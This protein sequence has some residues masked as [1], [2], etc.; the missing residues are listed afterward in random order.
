MS[1][2]PLTE[3]EDF[4]NEI[5]DTI[6]TETDKSVPYVFEHDFESKIIPLLQRPWD[7]NNLDSYR[8]YVHELFN[9]LRVFSYEP[10]PKV[11]F[12]VPALYPRPYTT[13]VDDP[14]AAT[15]GN[16]VEHLRLSAGRTPFAG[17]ELLLDFMTKI[18]IRE[19]VEVSTLIPLAKILANYGKTFLDD[20]N[21]P[22]YELNVVTE[23]KATVTEGSNV[24]ENETGD[25]FTD[26]Y[27]D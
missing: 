27:D 8:T 11:L 13:V 2:L 7:V 3:D 12:T 21:E 10:K 23:N 24:S 18:S 19:S 1:N 16:L 6:I 17:D 9:E 22:L 4:L 20:N 26:E 15:V 5:C 25:S 14:K